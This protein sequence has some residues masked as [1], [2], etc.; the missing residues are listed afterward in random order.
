MFSLLKSAL[1]SAAIITVFVISQVVLTPPAQ[2]HCDPPGPPRIIREVRLERLE[3]YGFLDD[4]MNG[5]TELRIYLGIS[6]PDHGHEFTVVFPSPPKYIIFDQDILRPPTLVIPYWH[7]VSPGPG[8]PPRGVY[9]L[10]G[11]LPAFHVECS[12]AVPV[13]VEV[14]LMEVSGDGVLGIA[15][16]IVGGLA[17]LGIGGPKGAVLGVGAAELVKAMAGYYDLDLGAVSFTGL[18]DGE[19]IR[20]GPSFGV[21]IEVETS[22]ML[23]PGEC[24]VKETGYIFPTVAEEALAFFDEMGRKYDEF[25]EALEFPVPE[26]GLD[27]IAKDIHPGHLRSV[28]DKAI[29]RA[30]RHDIESAR[31]NAQNAGLGR[32]ME[33]A[34]PYL[35]EGAE[36]EKLQD[37]KGVIESYGKA[38][39]VLATSVPTGFSSSGTLASTWGS[40]KHSRSE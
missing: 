1:P 34:E 22:E 38:Y 29:V 32:I 14:R 4:H 31:R 5:E 10:I 24:V 7:H 20:T 23:D 40:I 27:I 30:F 17:G 36:A 8:D 35:E 6:I 33:M 26:A 37:I 25:I 2:S 15:I 21:W 28:V 39:I 12:P 3:L 16:A 19:H 9:Q 18:E 13:D 11:P